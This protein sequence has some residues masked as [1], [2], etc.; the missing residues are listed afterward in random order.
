MRPT[1]I[2]SSHPLSHFC[3]YPSSCLS[4]CLF[5]HL[6][7]HYPTHMARF[8]QPSL[9]YSSSQPLSCPPWNIHSSMNLFIHLSSHLSIFSIQP[10]L[11]IH[12]SLHI[13]IS[14]FIHTAHSLN[15]VLIHQASQPSNHLNISTNPSLIESGCWYCKTS[16][17]V[18]ANI[19]V[20]QVWDSGKKPVPHLP[21]F[22]WQP[23]PT[24]VNILI[25]APTHPHQIPLPA[26]VWD[27][28]GASMCPTPQKKF[29]G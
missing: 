5:I 11:F 16:E 18:P 20:D 17:T 14:P 4:V 21:D 7:T 23:L 27:L 12:L 22:S 1:V 3:I 29:R 19:R 2:H 9:S 13:S 15:H 24:L 25:L 6:P 10:S 8:I 28:Y 26:L